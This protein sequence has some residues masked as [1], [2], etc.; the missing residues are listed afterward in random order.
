M[1]RKLIRDFVPGER[2]VE[3]RPIRGRIRRVRD[4]KELALLLAEKLVEEARELHD[5]TATRLRTLPVDADFA[6][7]S[8]LNEVADV[9]EVLRTLTKTCLVTVPYEDLAR[10]KAMEKGYF[11]KGYVWEW[12]GDEQ[13]RDEPR[14]EAAS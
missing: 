3:D 14:E 1:G 7:S 12:E 11:S 10:T 13:P 9:F 5:A 2:A 4:D 6:N 8:V